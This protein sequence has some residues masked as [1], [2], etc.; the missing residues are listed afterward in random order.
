MRNPVIGHAHF[1]PV[2]RRKIHVYFKKPTGLWYAWST[3][4]HRTCREAVAAAKAQR[5]Q[6][7]FV[8]NFAKD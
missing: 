6:W 3:N 2:Y 7:Q 8:A 1:G 4:A 5:P